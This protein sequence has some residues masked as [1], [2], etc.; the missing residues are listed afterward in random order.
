MDPLC[1]VYFD[2]SLAWTRCV[3]STLIPHLLI[4]LCVPIIGHRC[5]FNADPF[6]IH[7]NEL[8]L[9]EYPNHHVCASLFEE[10]KDYFDAF[11]GAQEGLF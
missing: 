11:I 9:N 7:A 4:L 6:W 10:L 5:D 2:S 3:L 8:T 1:G